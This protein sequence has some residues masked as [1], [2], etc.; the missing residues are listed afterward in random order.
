MPDGP[1]RRTGSA[2]SGWTPQ[3]RSP[4]RCGGGRARGA[5]GRRAAH[6]PNLATPHGAKGNAR[7]NRRSVV[8]PADVNT[9]GTTFG[10][11]PLR[12][13]PTIRAR[14]TRWLLAYPRTSAKSWR[15]TR[16]HPQPIHNGCPHLCRLAGTVTPRAASPRRHRGRPARRR[17]R[18]PRRP[19]SPSARQRPS[20]SCTRRI[21]T[22]WQRRPLS[23]MSAAVLRCPRPA[24]R[25][26]AGGRRPGATGKPSTT[27]SW[28]GLQSNRRWRIPSGVTTLPCSSRSPPSGWSVRSPTG[29]ASS[30][31]AG[32]PAASISSRMVPSRR[33]SRTRLAR[34]RRPRPPSASDQVSCAPSGS[35]GRLAGL[36]QPSLLIPDVFVAQ[37]SSDVDGPAPKLGMVLPGLRNRQIGTTDVVISRFVVLSAPATLR[38]VGRGRPIRCGATPTSARQRPRARRPTSGRCGP[39]R[40]RRARRT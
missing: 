20:S 22:T 34:Q 35:A 8:D 4:D 10:S 1:R 5:G 40:A 26:P 30:S 6:R 38:S 12:A 3:R 29:V 25:P 28:T 27:N 18:S 21:V 17:R 14:P 15:A 2:R 11:W 32:R 33:P 13:R 39:A 37:Q 23:T 19:R 31:L 9:C 7:R 36:D 24:H 16:S